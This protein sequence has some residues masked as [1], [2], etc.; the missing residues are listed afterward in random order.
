MSFRNSD[1]AKLSIRNLQIITLLDSVSYGL[2]YPFISLYIVKLGGNQ[3]HAGI[4]AVGNLIGESLSPDV[5]KSF[6]HHNGK[7]YSLF[8]VLNTMFV[9]HLMLG[10]TNSYWFAI[11]LRILFSLINQAQNLCLDLLLNRASTEEEREI[12]SLNYSILSG[13]GYI[14]GPI[15]SGY[16]FDV[17]FGYTTTL[18][19][20]LTLMNSALLMKIKGD[21]KDC[22]PEKEV[23]PLLEKTAEKLSTDIRNLSKSDFNKNWDIL[24]M[25]YCFASSITVFFSKFSLIIKSNYEVSNVTVGYTTAYINIL[26]FS[27]AY[28][29]T[30]TKPI[31]KS[32]SEIFLSELIFFLLTVLTLLTCFA[33][34][35]AL[36]MVL[37]VPIILLRMILMDLWKDLF[38]GRQNVYLTKLN[39]S[40][41]VFAGLTTPVVFGIICNRMAKDAVILFSCVPLLICW[42]TMKYYSYNSLCVENKES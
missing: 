36:F 30:L 32:Y 13:T 38:K 33:P 21:K 6:S 12:V 5:I 28:F 26:V 19:A 16:L 14:L 41:S 11:S 39:Q 3:Y 17:G 22:V 27:A 25:R 7:R 29:T 4:Y 40:A 23:K 1:N 37:L 18:A 42:I 8:L 35:Y 31:L 24:L 9:T 34:Y 2:I 15:L 10:I 20:C